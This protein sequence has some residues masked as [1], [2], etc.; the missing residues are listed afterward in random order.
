MYHTR[1]QLWRMR[2]KELNELISEYFGQI[3]SIFFRYTQE[4]KTINNPNLIKLI[5]H[6]L[7][8]IDIRDKKRQGYINPHP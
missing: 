1:E 7:K 5:N 8:I 4:G 6:Y 2:P 3:Q